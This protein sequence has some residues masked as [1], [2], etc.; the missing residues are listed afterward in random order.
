[1]V[2]KKGDGDELSSMY[3]F[4]GSSTNVD[5]VGGEETASGFIQLLAGTLGEKTMG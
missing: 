5:F 4:S 3:Q 1:V 2:G